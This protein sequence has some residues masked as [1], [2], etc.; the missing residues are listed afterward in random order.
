MRIES[1]RGWHSQVFFPEGPL[2]DLI[3][4]HTLRLTQIKVRTLTQVYLAPRAGQNALN[5]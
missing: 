5:V 3:E 2:N 4:K 1:M